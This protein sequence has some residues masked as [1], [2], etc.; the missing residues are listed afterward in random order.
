MERS[1]Q[2]TLI[3]LES[4]LAALTQYSISVQTGRALVTSLKQRTASEMLTPCSKALNQTNWHIL[5]RT[6]F[7]SATSAIRMRRDEGMPRLVDPPG[8]SPIV[9]DSLSLPTMRRA[10][11]KARDI[12]D[13]GGHF[14]A[15]QRVTCKLVHLKHIPGCMALLLSCRVCHSPPEI[16]DRK[17]P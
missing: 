6:L 5:P 2:E 8:Q 7:S 3:Q 14:V 15:K 12:T 10:S 17:L 1:R 9:V 13:D 4:S 11:Y 16:R